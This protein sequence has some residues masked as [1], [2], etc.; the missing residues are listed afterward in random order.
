MA[1]NLG[2]WPFERGR[3]FKIRLSVGCT[4]DGVP[5]AVDQRNDFHEFGC[6]LGN[7]VKVYF[8]ADSEF[9]NRLIL[10]QMY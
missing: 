2:K 5:L 8:G 6:Q 10:Q 9:A 1:E 3:V 4:G 7:V